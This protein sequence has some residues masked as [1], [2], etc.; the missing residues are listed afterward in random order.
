MRPITRRRRL[1][2]KLIAGGHNRC[3]YCRDAR[4]QVLTLEHLTPLCRGGDWSIGNLGVACYRCN[5]IKNKMTDA[6]FKNHLR[7]IGGHTALPL[8]VEQTEAYVKGRAKQIR[9]TN[10][11]YQAFDTLAAQQLERWTR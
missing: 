1:L 11:R 7:Q 2:E 10:G 3:R 5:S 6:E 9:A 4:L 8:L